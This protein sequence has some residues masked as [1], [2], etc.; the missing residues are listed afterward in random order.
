MLRH[1]GSDGSPGFE[2]GPVKVPFGRPAPLE[3][4]AIVSRAGYEISLRGDARIAKLQDAA[5]MVG[6]DTPSITAEGAASIELS[7]AGGW[8]GDQPARPLGTMQ[9]HS[10]LALVHGFN[11]PVLINS[12]SLS[13]ER[14]NVQVQNLSASAAQTTWHG[15]MKIPRKCPSASDCKFEMNLRTAE[16]DAAA[17][18]GLINPNARPAA[19]YKVLTSL[20]KPLP[21]LLQARGAGKL[22][23]DKLVV[24]NTVC[25]H[26][27]SEVTLDSGQLTLSRVSGEILGGTA[28]GKFKANF[29]SDPATFSGTGLVQAI[30]LGK[31]AELMHDG[32][33]SG[34]GM[35]TFQFDANGM[36]LP[37]II[38]SADLQAD[39]GIANSQFPHVV[40][41]S[42][43]EPLHAHDFSG[44]LLLHGGNF[45]LDDAKLTTSSG[46]YSVS[47]T[48]SLDGNLNFKMVSEGKPG[49]TVTGTLLKTRVSP[50]PAPATQAALRP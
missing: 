6:V 37:D 16:L 30:S 14:D 24:G 1:T 33:I 45:S 25:S 23:I 50:I 17:F 40:L 18:N 27:T 29:R 15:A 9:L 7:L 43:A 38:R 48:A 13:L 47:G 2:I 20:R 44:R 5:K 8:N 35:A 4:R 21:Y 49:F 32:W 46:V 42:R 28:A 41:A 31:V 26:F 22:T 11:A 10:V 3:V 12:A 36:H 39:F 34:E 19:W